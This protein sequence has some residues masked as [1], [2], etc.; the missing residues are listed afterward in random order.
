MGSEKNI[1]PLIYTRVIVH[2]PVNGRNQSN[3]NLHI[4]QMQKQVGRTARNRIF[5]PAR[6]IEIEH[7]G[8]NR[9]N[10]EG[11][12]RRKRQNF[13]VRPQLRSDLMRSAY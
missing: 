9:R 1:A 10:T 3:F 5:S 7:K 6:E 12:K 13:P 4:S 8:E 2:G 11:E